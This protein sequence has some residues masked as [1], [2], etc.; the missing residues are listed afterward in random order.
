M[1][2]L[3]LSSLVTAALAMPALADEPVI[4][5]PL[6]HL[7]AADAPK[8]RSFSWSGDFNHELLESMGPM[9]AGRLAPG[10]VVKGAPYSAEMVTE[11]NQMLADGNVISRTKSGAVYR[12][13]EG[14]TRQET[15]T[16]DGTARTVFINDPVAN[17]HMVLKPGAKRAVA[18]APRAMTFKY[19]NK[20]KQVVR[21][22]DREVRVEDGKV[23]ID[24]KEVPGASGRTAVVRG[25]KN[26]VI[27]NGR[28]TIDGKDLGEIAGKRHVTVQRVESEDGTQREEVRVQVVRSGDGKDLLV[29]PVAPTPPTPPHPPQPPAAAPLPP[30]PGVQT[31][32]FESTARLGK[33]IT[34][35]LGMKEFDGVKAEGKST[36]W[37]I[38]AGEIGNRNPINIMSETWYSPELQVTVYSRHS[39]PRTGESIY[40][41]ASIRRGE[42][43]ADLFRVPDDYKVKGRAPKG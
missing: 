24:G 1:Q 10:K 35:S 27:E 25:G 20:E 41:L 42:P 12:D 38:P 9:F 18:V 14:R 40:R 4:V 19:D 39:D 21:L 15:A 43:P 3:I 7:A 29:A 2:N 22:G 17:T 30:L 26:I 13:G 28:V 36:T 8:A 31:L 16:A 5:V 33:G 11:T 6:E 37:T 34:T 32:R 23:F